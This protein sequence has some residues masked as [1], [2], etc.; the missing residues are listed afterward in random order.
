[1]SHDP[2]NDK[3]QEF[4]NHL[5]DLSPEQR[6][7]FIDWIRSSKEKSSNLVKSVKAL[8]NCM[9]TLRVLVKY[10]M[11]DLEATRR[12]NQQLQETIAHL[13]EILEGRGDYADQ[14]GPRIEMGE[15]AGDEG[16]PMNALGGMIDLPLPETG[17]FIHSN[18]C[19][20]AYDA[21]CWCEHCEAC[22]VRHGQH[23][24]GAD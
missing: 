14:D 13:T 11:F 2:L 22:R 15:W 23:G 10:T 4:E 18:E 16:G 6:D 1:M 20:H 19:D 5:R 24:N 17:D 12:E 3:L 7:K 21:Q 9:D 8:S